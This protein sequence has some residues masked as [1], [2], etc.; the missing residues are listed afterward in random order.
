M[1]TKVGSKA[2][3]TDWVANAVQ[4]EEDAAT[5]RGRLGNE[6]HAA[7]MALLRECKAEGIEDNAEGREVIVKRFN[8]VVTGIINEFHATYVGVSLKEVFPTLYQYISDIRAKSGAIMLCGY[9]LLSTSNFTQLRQKKLDVSKAL[10]EKAEAGGG[11]NDG[12]DNGGGKGPSDKGGA[13][14]D[15]NL[16]DPVAVVVARFEKQLHELASRSGNGSA[17][18][19]VEKSCE[20]LQERLDRLNATKTPAKAAAAGRAVN[21]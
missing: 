14:N 11:T 21:H 6:L 19:F 15:A 7:T 8:E 2:L 4:Y 18:A 9:D 12:A 10:K 17:V 16:P 3:F 5:K 1:T 13:S 20:L